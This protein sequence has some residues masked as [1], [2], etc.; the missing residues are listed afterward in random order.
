MTFTTSKE[1]RALVKEMRGGLL[2]RWLEEQCIRDPTKAWQCND[3]YLTFEDHHGAEP[4]LTRKGIFFD[5]LH[6]TTEAK[7]KR[8]H[9]REEKNEFRYYILGWVPRP[10]EGVEHDIRTGDW[11]TVPELNR[12]PELTAL[13]DDF[14]FECVN[15]EK[16]AGDDI[17]WSCEGAYRAFEEWCGRTGGQDPYHSY[18]RKSAFL[19]RF[20][21]SLGLK[22]KTMTVKMVG[23]GLHDGEM[24]PALKTRRCRAYP[25]IEPRDCALHPA[26]PRWRKE[27][28]GA[29]SDEAH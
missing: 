4:T 9:V 12:G 18:S 20:K 13:I 24:V 26:E 14:V 6:R 15:V 22:A 3:M 10:V 1:R 29:D 16:M 21:Q 19:T 7:R 23:E 27:Y 5:F 8:L 28:T 25:G 11:L 17:R 2:A